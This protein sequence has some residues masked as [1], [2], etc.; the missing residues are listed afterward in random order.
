[1]ETDSA[2]HKP[3]TLIAPP[4]S[5]G[6]HSGAPPTVLLPSLFAFVCCSRRIRADFLSSPPAL[7]NPIQ[8]GGALHHSVRPYLRL[9]FFFPCLL[10]AAA[11]A[12][13]EKKRRRDG[14]IR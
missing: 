13:G 4:Q 8:E 11:V 5:A 7:S 3:S 1:M 9:P 10:S 14:Q 12:A 6:L 2:H